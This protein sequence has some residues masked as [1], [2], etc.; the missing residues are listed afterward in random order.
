MKSLVAEFSEDMTPPPPQRP[1]TILN[2]VTQAVQTVHAQV[3]GKL[4]LKPNAKVPELWISEPNTNKPEVYPLLGDRYLLGRSSKT[5]DIVVRNPLV[6]QVHLSLSRNSQQRY[7]PFILKDEKS[8]NGIYQGKRRITKIVLEHGAVFTLGPPELADAVQIKYV[9][10]PPWYILMLRWS[11]YGFT[12]MSALFGLSIAIAWQ[13]VSVKPLPTSTSGPV[14]VYARDGQTPLRPAYNTVHREIKRLEEFS[15]YLS[16]AL[17]ASEDSRFYW[18]LG[19]DPIGVTRAVFVNLRGGGISE[20]AST[21]TQQLARSLFREYVGTEDSAGRKL[22]E[23]LVALKLETFYSKNDLLLAYLNRVYL[24]IDLYGFEDAAQFYFGKSARNI[25]LS[26]AATLVGMLPAPNAFNPVQ[27]YSLAVRYRD[28]VI[29]RML[30]LGMITQEEADRA[31]RSR[32]EVNSKAK[33]IIGN[34]IAPYFYNHVFAELESLLGV[35]LAREGNFIVETGLD[36]KIQAKAEESLRNSVAE[37]GGIYGFSQGAIATVDS[38][39]G[40]ILALAGGVDYQLSQFNRATQALRQP[41]STFKIFAYTAALKQGI[42]PNT[43]YSCEAFR[44][45]GV[46]FSPCERSSG[47][48]NMWQGMAQSENS[49]ALRIAQQAGLNNVVRQARELGIKSDLNPVPGLVLGQSEVTVLEMTG[50][51]TALANGG[52]FNSAHGIKRILDSSD[53][54][55]P[56]NRE[57]CRV[58]Y[59]YT[60]NPEANQQVLSPEVADTMTR[61]L[62]GVVQS[63]TGRGAAIGL[64]EEAGKTGTTNNGVDLWFVGYLPRQHFVTSVWLG[65]DDNSPTSGSSGQ[66]AQV[67]ANYM[68]EVVNQK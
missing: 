44:W 65:N 13:N 34:T 16:K 1:K 7:A 58:I 53:C 17:I 15:P 54:Q 60:D 47:F 14:V 26:E 18:H 23:A 55:D 46:S 11:L 10:P 56:N 42:S 49:V 27:N 3:M 4:K 28:G 61:M 12:G 35:G 25:N 67:W 20:G 41:G 33:E 68:N 38:Q 64:G 45:E 22:R 57:T 40:E 8:T 2:A 6:S 24:G 43:T 59:E 52:K 29:Y 32:I 37:M 30:K 9:N 39:T 21:L 5:S 66:A 63:G 48:I 19:V 51:L 31:R 50:A 36:P 62:Q